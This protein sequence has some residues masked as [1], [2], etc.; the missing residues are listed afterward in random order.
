MDRDS[1][2]DAVH[3]IIVAIGE[4][5]DRE[6]LR[7]TPRRVAEMYQGMLV[8][9]PLALTDFENPQYDQMI[10]VKDIPISSLCEHHLLPFAGKCHIGYIPDRRVVGLSKLV[11]VANYHAAS[12]QIQERLTQQIA[13][14][15]MKR[16]RP[17]GAG[18]IIEAEH[19]CMSIRGVRTPGTVTVTSALRGV[20]LSRPEARQEFLDI[21]R[22]GGRP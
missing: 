9:E 15:L 4:D 14:D 13:D 3:R 19:T 10:V 11:R 6:G 16:L 1:I 12:L 17:K 7:D 8:R 18:V 22:C 5:P 2:E 20:F 21:V